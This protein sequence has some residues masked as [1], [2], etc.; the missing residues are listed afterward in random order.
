MG[1]GGGEEE[2]TT[3]GNNNLDWTV[4]MFNSHESN[5]FPA[6]VGILCWSITTNAATAGQLPIAEEEEE[7]EQPSATEEPS[8]Q[9]QVGS[10]DGLT[11]ALNSDSFTTGDTITV[12]GTV[13]ELDPQS[14]ISIE[15]DD[16]LNRTVERELVPVSADNEFT[17]SF[18]AGE[19][20]PFDSDHS[21]E[22]S[23][24]YRMTLSYFTPDFDREV[25]EFIFEYTD[26]TTA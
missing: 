2:E 12:S 19:Q 13:E 15:V 14:Y 5:S 9:Q 11:A 16:P 23:G 20:R 3:D 24:N 18:V 4:I 6:A 25:V 7:E 1:G 8:R 17:Y 10:D 21:M 26:T 22:M